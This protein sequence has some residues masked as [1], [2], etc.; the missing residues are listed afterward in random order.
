ML[1]KL[2]QSIGTESSHTGDTFTATVANPVVAQDAFVAI[3]AGSL[4]RGRITGIHISSNPNEQSVI[5]LAFEDLQIRGTTYP[6]RASISNVV[7][8]RPAAGATTSPIVR[9][10]A[11]ISG[12]ELSRMIAGGVL[13]AAVGTVIS[14]GPG[15]TETG[16]PA[17][18]SLTVRTN[19]N[20]K[21]R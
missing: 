9:N 20:V 8:E 16:I 14:L 10:A 4:L 18:S 1:V 17:G 6:V 5:R 11:V 19:D 3:P 15:G 13:N 2:N 7:V 12:A 21:I